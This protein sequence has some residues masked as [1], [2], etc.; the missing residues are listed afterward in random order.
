MA[1]NRVQPG[2]QMHLPV[3]STKVSGDPEMV[4]DLP[5]VLLGDPDAG[6]EAD[7][8]LEGVFDLPVVASSGS[9]NSA[10]SIGDALYFD[11]D[12]ISK[13]ASGKAYGNAVE[14]IAAGGSATINVRLK[15]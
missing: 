4:G 2:K 3:T 12:E 15:G 14:A 1:L 11:E 8:A 5:V 13:D 10:V 9:A 7:C 6:N